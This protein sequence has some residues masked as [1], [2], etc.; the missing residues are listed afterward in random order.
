MRIALI[1]VIGLA[2]VEAYIIADLA[3]KVKRLRKKLLLQI[4][5]N[6][7]LKNLKTR[8]MPVEMEE[9]K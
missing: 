7:A 4:R 9:I 5:A 2:I 3:L 6:V 8:R 1:I